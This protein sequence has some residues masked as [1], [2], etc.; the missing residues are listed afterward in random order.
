MQTQII[1]QINTNLKKTFNNT[2]TFK[3]NY[4]YIGKTLIINIIITGAIKDY[5]KSLDQYLHEHDYLK[6][7]KELYN[8][9]INRFNNNR[10]NAISDS[11]IATIKNIG[12][13]FNDNDNYIL[14][15]TDN[16]DSINIIN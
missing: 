8:K 11:I 9:E 6:Y 4:E 16:G 10:M 15:I 5:F 7:Y 2:M 13:E 3:V 1:T 12:M 14:R